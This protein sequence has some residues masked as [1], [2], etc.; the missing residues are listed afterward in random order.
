MDLYRAI[1]AYKRALFLIPS[2]ETARRMQIEYCIVQ[3]YYLGYK[4]DS[5]VE[6]FETSQV[7]KYA[8]P[9]FPAY[10]DLL[11]IL[12]E[13]YVH[14]NQCEKRENIEKLI[15]EL[16]CTLA[17][18][19][20]AYTAFRSA[21]FESIAEVDSGT[22]NTDYADF[23]EQY[24]CASKSVDKARFYNAVIPGAGYLYVGQKKTALTSLV[25]NSLFI[26]A[27]YCFFDNGNIPA[28]LI[29]TSLEMGWYFGGINGAGLAAEEYNQRLY[30]VNAKEMMVNHKLFP[31]LMIGTS[32]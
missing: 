12:F 8:E 30:E 32:F 2:K 19:L 13:C 1:T 31:I 15:R 17:N 27:A 23:L 9:S 21:D 7:V 16:D 28:G 3:A 29:T 6:A 24:C 4:Y 14:V 26:A 22:D 5:A 20:N 25:I 11:I 10:R 18:D